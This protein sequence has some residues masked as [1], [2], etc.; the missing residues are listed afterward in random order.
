MVEE[1]IPFY[2]KCWFWVI[3]LAIIIII[4]LVYESKD[5]VAAVIT[6]VQTT[7]E[8]SAENTIEASPETTIQQDIQAKENTAQSEVIPSESTPLISLEPTEYPY[9]DDFANVLSVDTKEYIQNS[10]LSLC[11]LTGAE[12]VVVTID[13]LDGAEISDYCK[14][15]F[16]DWGI[17]SSEKNN[18]LLILLSIEDENYWAMQGS[19][20][21]ADLSND[22]IGTILNDY[23]EPSFAAGK[24]DEGVR[25]VFDAFLQYFEDLYGINDIS[26]NPS[27]NTLSQD[28]A[29]SVISNYLEENNLYIPN[30]I[31]IADEDETSY[32]IHAFDIETYDQGT[33]QE[34]TT[35]S[36]WYTIDKKTG[37]IGSVPRSV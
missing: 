7:L 8:T 29:I 13:S 21:E 36:G 30:H 23:L 5:K 22:T 20:L 34:H 14:N 37:E 19:G 11:D 27:T 2:K 16:N 28:D 1:K 26:N 15:L 33:D 32:T 4:C 9:A 35:S 18:G 17:G 10:N 3:V 12:I 24:Y 6:A 25:S 31:E